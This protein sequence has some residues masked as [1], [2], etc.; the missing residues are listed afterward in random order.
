[1]FMNDLSAGNTAENIFWH[2]AGHFSER[3]ILSSRRTNQEFIEGKDIVSNVITAKG[4]GFETTEVKAIL[5]NHFITRDN[6]SLRESGTLEFELWSNA[7]AED[8]TIK[9][10]RNW[11][12]G[13][14]PAMMNPKVFNE[15]MA[16]E[17]SS[18]TVVAPD[19]LAFMLCDDVHGN[20]PYACILFSSF[21][22]LK[23]RLKKIAATQEAPFD[24]EHLV[25]PVQRLGFW[26][27]KRRNVPFNTWYV[28]LDELI[29]LA[30]ITLFDDVP[31]RIDQQKKCP[32][33]IQ[34][35]RR[36]YLIAH[37]TNSIN[38]V[39][40]YNRQL[41]AGK[42]YNRDRGLS[43]NAEIPHMIYFD[44]SKL[45]PSVLRF[46]R[47]PDWWKDMYKL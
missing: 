3:N 39:E 12:I 24:L 1:M 6:D 11:T 33:R 2:F 10:R 20:K 32:I 26:A 23:N 42:A 19:Q 38:R 45:P 17:D 27:D 25:P 46:D 14:L 4:F 7:W 30:Q 31:I 47:F 16:Q 40:E 28:P 36:D 8:G 21:R 35:S 44:S 9:P 18:V 29:D 13:W 41:V 34:N 22:K 37:S 5:N 43:E 15:F